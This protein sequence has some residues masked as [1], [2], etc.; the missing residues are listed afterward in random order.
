MIRLWRLRWTDERGA[1][2]RVMQRGRA[3][4]RH[5]HALKHAG[6]LVVVD[7]TEAPAWSNPTVLHPTTT[8]PTTTGRSSDADETVMDG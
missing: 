4:M 1:N 5:A 2:T 3:A 6:H 7:R 8:A